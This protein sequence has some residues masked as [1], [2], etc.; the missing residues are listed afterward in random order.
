MD[1][2]PNWADHIVA[3]IFCVLI[4][5]HA[6]RLSLRQHSPAV[7]NSRQK[8]IF[9]FSTSLSLFIMATLV[10]SVWLLFKRPLLGLGLT[11]DID[12][13]S[14]AWV[15]IAFVIIYIID[16]I[17]TV[18]TPKNIAASE[19]EWKSR[20]P[21]MPTRMQELPVYILMCLCAAVFEEIIYRGY[22]VTYFGYLFR[23]AEYRQI[24]S[25]VLPALFCA[26][27]HFYHSM[28]NIIKAF[29]L[30]IFFG[31]IFIQSGSLV[32]VTLLHFSINVMGGL[33]TV[34]YLGRNTNLQL[35]AKSNLDN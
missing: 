13:R 21:F 31:Y 15:V 14:S 10:I 25:V 7:Y 33:L 8:R 29:I 24:F 23:G 17:I 1:K 19:R 27:A 11:F 18:A 4:P 9:Y 32:I 30:S 34:K 6:I 5:F 22:L 35:T 12:I 20:T 3:I 16:L 28:K 2:F 26:I